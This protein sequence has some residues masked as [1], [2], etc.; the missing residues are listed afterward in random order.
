METLQNNIICKYYD[1]FW[2]SEEDMS[3]RF[4][5]LAKNILNN[6]S[7]KLNEKI[8][9]ITE[10]EFYLFCDNHKDT[11]VHKNIIQG[12]RLNWYFHKSGNSYKSGNYKGLDITFSDQN[13]PNEYFG[14]LIRSISDGS[15]DIIGPCKCVNKLLEISNSEN[16]Q[17]LIEKMNGDVNIVGNIIMTLVHNNNDDEIIYKSP[18]VGLSMKNL[19]YCMR[20]YRYSTNPV[21]NKYLYALHLYRKN[22]PRDIIIQSLNIRVR[23]LNRYIAFFEN[24]EKRKTN[25]SVDDICNNYGFIYN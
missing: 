14:I 20:E 6:I 10:V 24:G 5:N 11:Y 9:K 17:E 21:K 12:N 7:I 16:I 8:L 22:I 2:N 1:M 3:D 4:D 25:K 23:Y 18:R 15:D 13:K 19:E